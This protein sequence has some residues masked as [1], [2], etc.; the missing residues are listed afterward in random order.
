MDGL[1]FCIFV[2]SDHFVTRTSV[3]KCGMIQRLQTVQDLWWSI[4]SET[5]TRYYYYIFIFIHQKAGSSKEQ[6][7]SIKMYSERVLSINLCQSVSLF[8][9]LSVTNC[10]YFFLC[11]SYMWNKIIS[12][13]CQPLLK[14]VWNNF[15]SVR[16][17]SP[18]TISKLFQ[19]LDAAHNHKYFPA[20]WMLLN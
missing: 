13:L 1:V 16:G 5:L 11:R 7:S 3:F 18:E 12:K 9:C 6:T 2:L 19:W 14:S 8:V 17:N 15:I 4:L 10:H 20:C